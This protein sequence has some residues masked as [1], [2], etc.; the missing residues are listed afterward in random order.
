MW[1]YLLAAFNCSSE[2]NC[3]IS[4]HKGLKHYRLIWKYCTCTGALRSTTAECEK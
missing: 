2:C 3:L 4:S 1:L